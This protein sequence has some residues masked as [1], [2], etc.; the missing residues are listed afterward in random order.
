MFN[1]MTSTNR[2]L[3]KICFALAFLMG[4]TFIY[5]DNSYALEDK[6]FTISTSNLNVNHVFCSSD[7]SNYHYLIIETNFNTNDN[8]RMTFYTDSSW[9]SYIIPYRMNKVIIDIK[10]FNF[11]EYRSSSQTNVFITGDNTITFTLTNSIGESECPPVPDCDTP[12]IIQDFRDVFF[13]IVT[14]VIPAFGVI[15]VVWFGIDI[16]SSLFFGRGK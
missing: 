7:C 13:A 5:S 15:V 11:L 14:Y 1:S 6:S 8:V 4:F 9:Y 12:Q 2:F 16:M 3:V 10:S